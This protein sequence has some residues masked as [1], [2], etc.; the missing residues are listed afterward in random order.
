[1]VGL[2]RHVDAWSTGLKAAF[3]AALSA[4][5]LA[6]AAAPASAASAWWHLTSGA[7][8]TELSTASSS[9]EVQEV[10]VTPSE[11]GEFILSEPVATEREE[12]EVA[13]VPQFAILS[14]VA[15]AAQVEEGLEAFY[16][17][18]T[19]HVTGGP[20]EGGPS[21]Y[22][23]TFTGSR[24]YQAEPLIATRWGEL[25]GFTTP[26]QVLTKE[27]V[28]A[29]LAHVIVTAANLGNG[30]INGAT[31]IVDRLPAGLKAVSIEG[32]AGESA[33]HEIGPVTCS[34]GALSCT[35][36]GGLPPF[37]QIEIRVGV[38]VESSTAGSTNEVSVVGGGAPATSISRPLTLVNTPTPTQ[39]GFEGYEL[40]LEEERG[41][42]DTQAG[43]H[44]FQFT[45][46]LMMNGLGTA[47]PA[48]LPKD[49][50]VKL[51]P[52]LV[53][54]TTPFKRCSSVQFLT[55]V[56]GKDNECPAQSAIGIA[57]LTVNEPTVT[58][59]TTFVVP[60]YNLEP[61]AGEPA[62]FG[63]LLLF[64]PVVLDTS[65]RTGGDYGITASSSNISEAAGF[66]K[67]EFTLWGVPGSPSHDAQR[68]WG[69]LEVARGE[70][71]LL[72]CDPSGETTPSPFLDLPTSCT[73]P[74]QSSVEADSW[75]EP[76][77]LVST[78]M[79]GPPLAL[80]GCGGLR[81]EPSISISSVEHQASTPTGFGLDLHIPQGEMTNPTGRIQA[82]LKNATV[83]LPEGLMLNPSAAG[84]LLACSQQQIGLDSA[85]P[86]S[87][88]EA[89]KVGTV[90]VKTPLL[91][92]PLSGSVY[93]AAQNANP[94]GSLVAM[95]VFIEDP[96]SGSR[97]KLAGDVHLTEAGQ[98]VAT[99]ENTPQLPF[100][101]FKMHFF[102]GPRAALSTP[103]TCGTYTTNGSFAPWSGGA[104]AQTSAAFPIDS[105]PNAAPC[106][107]PLPFTPSLTAGSANI[108][109]GAFTDFT[110]TISR[111][112]GQQSL[113][114]V[115]LHMSPGLS[116]LLTG[117]ELCGEPQAEE[118]TCGP[119][120]LIGE[121]TVSVGVGGSP[122]TV[123][124]GRVY[125]TGPYNGAP[126]GLSI[127]DPAKAGPYDLGEGAC[128]CVLVRAKVEV[129]P[130]TAQL[131]IATDGSGP[132][133]IPSFLQ[134]I[135]LQIK[136]V[137]VTITRPGFTFNPTNCDPLDITGTLTSA[138]G[139]TSSQSLPFQ[140]MNCGA[141]QFAPKFTVS[142][143][144]RTSKAFGASLTSRLVYPSAPLGSQA[145]IASVKVDLP[146][147]LPS[148]LS[149]LQKACLAA[150]FETNPANCPAASI[151]GHAK[152]ITPVLPVPLTGPAYFVSHGGE[153]FPS[154][155]MVLQGYG[156][157][158]DLV[159]STLIRKGITSTN[160]KSAPDVPFSSFE[161][162]LPEGRYSALA[163]NGSLCKS[164]LSMPTQL[165][166]Q[167]GT[168]IHQTT[169]IAVT[170]CPKSHKHSA[171]RRRR[172]K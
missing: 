39:F 78:T 172:R 120:S 72:P 28:K 94:F 54:N 167:N 121:T 87:C 123:T 24:N 77:E 34:L 75:A 92:N 103:S 45:T 25:F 150:T 125:L 169:K 37:N 55:R 155:T 162:T 134:G 147:Q 51:P 62:R 152:V 68:G 60:V 118:G 63:T 149:T 106:Q 50:N 97:V 83:A 61:G 132:H 163:A 135:P 73:G 29:S 165:V 129:D 153:A 27:L 16:G 53:G 44:P 133:S 110:T 76:S 166:A 93:V 49:V 107:D 142:T 58:H 141:L 64:T 12:F 65:L 82:N 10:K 81:F 84:G 115:Q 145:N 23:V 111:E 136:H 7:R 9:S 17:A 156:V 124:G 69:C 38:V 112:D 99:F 31:T 15:T 171:R 66:L 89:A 116:G 52:G 137:N 42:Q 154:L 101:D 21:R 146:H 1:M 161:L 114:S 41:G 48:A 128:D 56:E 8:P 19:V 20:E 151:V 95:Y 119:E 143:S 96:V 36:A 46:T 2:G 144:G 11:G 67:A 79:T 59:L 5:L 126:F 105:G 139:A 74:L 86:A 122:F 102:D 113:R 138:Q 26:G 98:I 3:G 47:Q 6:A 160:F 85:L 131:T 100:E 14:D 4:L 32:I 71:P 90:E 22:V 157:T 159:G 148:R 80:A 13:G 91:T 168:V 140:V 109:A 104:A 40:G 127:V 57:R 35:Y 18:G 158:V 88:P 43:S 33:E 30:P 108:R 130:H 164:K 170:A 70:N 117:I